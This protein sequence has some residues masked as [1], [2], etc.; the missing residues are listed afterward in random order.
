M[1]QATNIHAVR[2]RQL[3]AEK[4]TAKHTP[5][6]VRPIKSLR[7]REASGERLEGY[8]DACIAAGKVTGTGDDA[9]VEL[10]SQQFSTIR[11]KY[12]PS[13]RQVN[14]DAKGTF[15]PKFHRTPE[16]MDAIRV[17]FCEPCQYYQPP[18]DVKGACCS[19][20]I[21][22]GGGLVRRWANKIYGCA[23]PEGKELWKAE[24]T[25]PNGDSVKK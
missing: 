21:G 1:I 8:A 15:N 10:T 16:E 14:L 23:L 22:C 6:Y 3:R 11:N 20:V 17:K 5:N 7:F 18:T 9:T 2:S 13:V 24:A 25:L 12:N 19:L 4:L